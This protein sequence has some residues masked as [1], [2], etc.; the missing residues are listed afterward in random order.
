MSECK[1]VKIQ[2]LK[3]GEMFKRKPDSKRVYVLQGYEWVVISTR[4]KAGPIRPSSCTSSV[5]LLCMLA[6]LSKVMK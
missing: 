6:L 5:M 2:Y 1:A 4:C 3:I